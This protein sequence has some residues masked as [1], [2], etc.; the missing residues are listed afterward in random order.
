MK[1]RKFYRAEIVALE[2]TN[3]AYDFLNIF[4]TYYNES[5]PKIEIRLKRKSILSPWITEG[6]LKSSK[7]KQYLYKKF[8]KNRTPKNETWYKECKNL[9]ETNTNLKNFTIQNKS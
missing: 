4:S 9:L 1:L 7:R 6:I 8:L 5:L 2:D 3:K